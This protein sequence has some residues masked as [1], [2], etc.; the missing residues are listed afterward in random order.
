MK[1]NN[2]ITIIIILVVIL[3]AI[4]ILNKPKDNVDEQTAI[5]I[6]SKSILY[7]Q[8]GCHAC[9][10]Q[11]EMFGKNYKHLNVVDCFYE[12]NKCLEISATPTWLINGQYYKG[13]QSIDNLKLLTGC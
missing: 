8:L 1:N 4:I 13:V 2:L 3:I 5:C 7:I 12:K 9:D 10:I 6:G 11:E